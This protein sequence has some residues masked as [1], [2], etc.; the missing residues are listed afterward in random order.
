M[1]SAK[2]V[3]DSCTVHGERIISFE[4][5]LPRIVL[6]ELNT[7]GILSKNSASSR[8]IP[9]EKMLRAVMDNP[10]IPE[11]WGKNQK[12]MVAEAYL[13]GAEA[14]AARTE[15]LQARDNAVYQTERLLKL[16]VHKQ[17]ANRLLEPFAWHTVLLTGT[18]WSNFFNL[19]NNPSAHPA[20]QVPA[21]IM[22]S[23]YD[24]CDPK[25]LKEGE[26]H[27]PYINKDTDDALWLQRGTEPGEYWSTAR[28]VSAGRC[29]RLSYL[30]HNGVRDHHEDV[31]LHDRLLTAGHMS[32][33]EHQA[34]PMT[35][36]ERE[37][38]RLYHYVFAGTAFES[39]V[40]MDGTL[41]RTTHF[42]GKFNGLVP[43]RKVI[44][45]E[46]DILSKAKAIDSAI[47]SLD[48]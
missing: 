17:L 45:Y 2:V 10:Y 38:Y 35:Y 8:A 7:H 31:A 33:M 43:Y 9:V 25:L 22:Q 15:W 47:A 44:P 14:E 34:R 6:A 18:E 21:S 23:L 36:A 1:Y 12:G 3:A 48:K 42:C 19:R 37:T 11:K 29:A 26:W 16:E 32:P 40:P 46:H 4:V 27:L 24:A 28:A 39:R 41:V 30:T 5:C 20:I 13:E